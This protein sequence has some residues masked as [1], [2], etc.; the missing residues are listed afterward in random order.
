MGQL[1][2]SAILVSC[3]V[4]L[5]AAGMG[6]NAPAAGEVLGRP[7]LP[8]HLGPDEAVRAFCPAGLV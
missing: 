2:V 7:R 8:E 3:G 4:L 1:E 6:G 5:A